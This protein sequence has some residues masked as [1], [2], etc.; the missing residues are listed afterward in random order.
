MVR[1]QPYFADL[2]AGSFILDILWYMDEDE[3]EK[4]KLNASPLVSPSWSWTS[5]GAAVVYGIP[6]GPFMRRNLDVKSRGV[7]VSVLVSR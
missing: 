7:I 4:K 3:S 1:F 2:W 5:A 6:Q